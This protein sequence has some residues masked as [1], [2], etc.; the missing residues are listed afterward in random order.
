LQPGLFQRGETA[1]VVDHIEEGIRSGEEVIE[2]AAFLIKH[3]FEISCSS[4]SIYLQIGNM[5]LRTADASEEPAA[6]LGLLVL[7]IQGRLEV[8]SARSSG[9][10]QFLRSKYFTS[11][12]RISRY[13]C[14]SEFLPSSSQLRSWSKARGV[15]FQ[16]FFDS[17]FCTESSLIVYLTLPAVRPKNK[18]FGLGVQ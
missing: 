17:T 2:N 18:T 7:L 10:R 15:R 3:S 6:P 5:A 13:F 12:E 11:R 9:A 14:P 4:I 16:S 8:S 1:V